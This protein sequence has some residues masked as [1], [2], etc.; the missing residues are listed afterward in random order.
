MNTSARPRVM[1]VIAKVHL[2]GSEEVALS[3]TE[4]LR[5]TFDFSFFSVLGVADDAV[6]RSM[7]ER[8]RAARVPLFTGT[9]LDMKRGGLVHGAARL[10]AALNHER[11]DIVHLHTDVPDATFAA[12]TLLPGRLPRPAVVRTVHNT[13]LWPKWDRLGAW[14]EGRIERA[15]MV[16]VS[17]AAID[18]LHAY[19]ARHGLPRLPDA[20]CQVVYNGVYRDVEPRGP[21]RTRARPPGPV[22]VLFAGRFEH[23]KGCDLLPAIFERAAA[24][25]GA[26]AEVTI[27]GGGAYGPALEAWVRS[28]ALPWSVRVVSPIVGLRDRLAE[29]DVLIM[30]SRFEGLA[31]LCI[32][33]VLAGLP[34]IVADVD[35]MRE[36]FP[37]RAPLACP[38]EDVEAFA[39]ALASV[40]SDI[41][42]HLRRADDL[43]PGVRARFGMQRMSAEYRRVYRTV[44]ALPDA[45]SV[46]SARLNS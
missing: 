10:W 34:T 2:G 31:L 45:V 12:A 19:R 29:Y 41:E 8:L 16:G 28:T 33:S 20:Q 39:R 14:V 18:H 7:R 37:R 6:G 23:Q 26:P 43:I 22:R 4:S 11:P 25:T 5:D 30:P 9:P 17:A 38:P 27:A 24:L 42:P 40:V 13:V 1:H 15:Q 21:E 44:L 32:E 35:G 46:G 3:I 36:V